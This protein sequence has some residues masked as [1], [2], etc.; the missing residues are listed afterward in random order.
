MLALVAAVVFSWAR[1]IAESNDVP[2]DEDYVAARQILDTEGFDRDRD[3]LVILPPWSL[4]PLVAVGD[5][6]PICGDAIA[7]RPMH[8]W[9]RLWAIVEPDADD[10]RQALV[11]RRGPPAF[12]REAG[13]VVIER[14]DLPAPSVTY[15]LAA[16]LADASVRV[17]GDGV[18]ND[19]VRRSDARGGWTC[20]GAQRVTREH[21]LVT[22]N[23]DLAV[24]AAPPT[25]G[26]RL[27]IAWPSVLAGSDV[28]VTAG[29]T[30]DGADK[31]KV[32][33]RLRVLIDGELAGMVVRSP[34]LLFATDV[35][36]TA[37]FV[38]RTVSV[39]FAIDSDDN[40]AAP[41]AFDAYV[42]NAP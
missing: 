35:I 13:R 24:M 29:F 33:V 25:A 23:A 2:R 26:S 37:G 14:W 5:L 30:R 3:A 9:A 21:L 27:E 40:N 22:D 10:P 7:D 41:F 20:P 18:S 39:T 19:C 32:P 16:H 28:I 4:R 17:V 1:L 15:D 8:R 34:A 36:D 31:A 11:A 6:E 38:G 42:V 12:S